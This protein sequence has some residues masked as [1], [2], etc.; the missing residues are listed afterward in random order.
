MAVLCGLPE[1][2]KPDVPWRESMKVQDITSRTGV[3]MVHQ[4][5]VGFGEAAVA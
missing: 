4:H 1:L 3:Y 5:E 2:C